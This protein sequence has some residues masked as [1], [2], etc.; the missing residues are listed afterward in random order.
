[1]GYDLRFVIAIWETTIE[2][3]RVSGIARSIVNRANAFGS[4]Y[5]M[6]HLAQGLRRITRAALCRLRIVVN[7]L[8]ISDAARAE[9]LS[10]PDDGIDST[11][12]S[13][14]RELLTYMMADPSASPSVI[15]LLFSAKSIESIGD[16][17]TNISDAVYYLAQGQRPSRAVE[18][19]LDRPIPTERT[20]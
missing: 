12:S 16:N 9:A 17:A 1:M 5:S 4:V 10:V 11:Y 7:S 13:L 15:Q 2:L 8:V 18:S 20:S 19:L 6:P 3:D 14:C